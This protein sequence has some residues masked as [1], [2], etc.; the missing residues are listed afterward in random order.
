MHFC[1]LTCVELLVALVGGVVDVFLPRVRLLAR[2]KR[3]QIVNARNAGF[4][5]HKK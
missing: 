4:Q 2:E 5:L 1:I 3:L